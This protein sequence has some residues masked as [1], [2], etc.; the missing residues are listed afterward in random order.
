MVTEGITVVRVEMGIQNR[1]AIGSGYLSKGCVA[2]VLGE[3]EES[4]D[5]QMKPSHRVE[6]FGVRHAMAY[7]HRYNGDMDA[8]MV[9]DCSPGR[10]R[11]SRK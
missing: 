3:L 4:G 8:L 2:R 5:T 11:Q 6:M 10:S 9:R 7:Y 1:S